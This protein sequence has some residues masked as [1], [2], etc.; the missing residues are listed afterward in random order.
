VSA[1]S[2][3]KPRIRAW[4]IVGGAVIGAAAI[5]GA[6]GLVWRGFSPA[7]TPATPGASCTI[8]NDRLQCADSSTASLCRDGKWVTMPCRGPSGCTDWDAGP[9]CDDDFGQAGE[10]CRVGISGDNLA[11]TTDRLSE[12][13]CLAGTW[14][15]AR[16]CKGAKKC[17][18][19]GTTPNCDDSL[20]DVGDPCVAS[21]SESNFACATNKTMEVVCDAPSKTLQPSITCR[22]PKGCWV[23]RVDSSKVYCDQSMARIGDKCGPV[24]NQSC[25]VDAKQELKCSPQLTWQKQRDCKK[26]GCKIKNSEVVCD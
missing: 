5:V 20:G 8:G 22:G 13:T 12:L 16:T 1:A 25:S 24:D 3:D 15:L 23:D 17:I 18:I 14:A 10:P 7:P 9:E 21:A 11:C 4:W 6:V 2:S 19:T 26:A